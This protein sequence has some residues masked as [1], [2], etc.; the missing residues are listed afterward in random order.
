MQCLN[1]NEWP[2]YGGLWGIMQDSQSDILESRMW[3]ALAS[4]EVVSCRCI[5]THKSLWSGHWC[6]HPSIGQCTQL[7]R[8]KKM[9]LQILR[10]LCFCNIKIVAY[11]IPLMTSIACQV[12]NPWAIAKK[13]VRV[14]NISNGRLSHV[15]DKWQM[16]RNYKRQ[17]CSLKV[18][19][20][21]T[22]V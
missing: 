19:I 9:L 5:Y 8:T 22:G 7:E 10:K 18:K 16:W 20:E 11:A 1:P 2:F 13:L 6:W 17:R 3:L 12:N 14:I 21:K 4:T 15:N